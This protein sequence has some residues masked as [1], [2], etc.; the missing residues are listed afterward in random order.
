[1]HFCIIAN[2]QIF[3]MDLELFM[4]SLLHRFLEV[5]FQLNGKYVHMNNSLV[6]QVILDVHESMHKARGGV[7]I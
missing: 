2:N 1:M 7:I 3:Q 4:W 5:P 6:I